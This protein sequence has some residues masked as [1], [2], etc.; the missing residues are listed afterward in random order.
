MNPITVWHKAPRSP[1][2]AEKLLMV[3]FCADSRGE[4]GI[5]ETK[6]G[7]FIAYPIKYLTTKKEA[8]SGVNMPKPR[9]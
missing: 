7:N 5:C 9:G 2:E 8:V 3:G 6:E 4:R 1:E